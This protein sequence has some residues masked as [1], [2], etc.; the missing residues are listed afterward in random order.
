MITAFIFFIH[1]I[2][3]LVI[4]T[5]KWQTESLS[6]AFINIILIIILFSIGWSLTTLLAKLLFEPAGFGIHFDRD[7]ISLSILTVVEFFF[8]RIYFREKKITE[9]G[10]EKQ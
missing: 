6:S 1:F 10:M 3:A 8:Y 4:F 9:A 2:F 5:K 7:T